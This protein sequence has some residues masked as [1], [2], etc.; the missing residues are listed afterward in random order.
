MTCNLEMVYDQDDWATIITEAELECVAYLKEREE[1]FGGQNAL[2]VG[3]GASHFLIELA[4]I[5]GR[6]DGL[7]IIEKELDVAYNLSWIGNYKIYKQNKYDLVG[8]DA[9]LL[10]DYQAIVDVN[11][12]MFSCCQQ[13]FEEYFRFIAQRLAPGGVLLSH[14]SGFGA[15]K[16]DFFPSMLS[17]REVEELTA[18]LGEEFDLSLVDS[19]LVKGESIIVIRR[20][21]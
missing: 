15:Y 7:T 14:S 18:G 21:E 20:A 4:H 17:M 6:I 9:C 16:D 10:P 8:M 2:D 13:H 12:K 19:K 5:F 3:I 11:L 1:E